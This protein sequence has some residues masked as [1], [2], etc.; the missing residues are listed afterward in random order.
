MTNELY[1]I[2]A[3]NGNNW[4]PILPIPVSK[5]HAQELLTKH[6]PNAKERGH[7][8]KIITVEEFKKRTLDEAPPEIKGILEKLDQ[9]F[10][11]NSDNSDNDTEP[12]EI[13]DLLNTLGSVMS[14]ICDCDNCKSKRKS[15][16]EK[17]ADNE[18]E[19]VEIGFTIINMKNSNNVSDNIVNA[20][21]QALV[22]LFEDIDLKVNLDEMKNA[23]QDK[24]SWK[25]FISKTVNHDTPDDEEEEFPEDMPLQEVVDAASHAF[26]K[27]VAD[28]TPSA[29][30]GDME[31]M[32]VLAFEEAM[33]DAVK[34]WRQNNCYDENQESYWYFIRGAEIGLAINEFLE[35][36]NIEWINHFGNLEF[37][38]V[39]MD[40]EEAG[41]FI[42]H[43]TLCEDDEDFALLDW[44]AYIKLVKHLRNNNISVDVKE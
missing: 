4:Q 26:W 32:A 10:S 11:D 8:L 5:E 18:K 19:L 6:E 16:A 7:T 22:K 41:Q 3:I 25:L 9:L 34:V 38:K 24:E 30:S 42:K 13:K 28:N 29:K 2:I 14:H 31:P 17:D 20:A 39:S 21:W 15:R 33:T 40:K 23:I 35:D 43:L 27:V 36:V 12:D 37:K 44:E 1:T